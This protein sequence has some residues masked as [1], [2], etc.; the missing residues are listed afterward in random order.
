M[1][2]NVEIG[3]VELE[4]SSIDIVQDLDMDLTRLICVED[5]YTV[6]VLNEM[7]SDEESSD[8]EGRGEGTR[9]QSSDE[10]A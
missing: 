8:D 4:Y 2:S 1:L 3:S 9:G 6:H 7:T 10:G 5:T